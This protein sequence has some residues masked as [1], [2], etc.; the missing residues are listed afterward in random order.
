MNN[1]LRVLFFCMPLCTSGQSAI[2]TSTPD[3]SAK[4]EVY[5]TNQGFLAPRVTLT[6]TGDVTT[7]KNAAG[8]TVTPATGLMV[9]NT[10]T[11]GTGSTAVTPG[12][13]AYSGSSWVR[14]SASPSVE[15]DATNIGA[16]P[17]GG[18]ISLISPD[19]TYSYS[20]LGEIS[21]P[22]GKWE[23]T[24]EFTCVISQLGFLQSMQLLNG[25]Y[26]PEYTIMN[27]YWISDESYATPVDPSYPLNVSGLTSG[28]LTADKSFSGSNVSVLSVSRTQSLQQMKFYI[29]NSGTGN[30]TYF[31]H[32]HETYTGVSASVDDIAP[33][34]SQSNNNSNRFYAV[35]IQ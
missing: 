7:I 4:F 15:V 12:Y 30:K 21:L 2:G 18:G 3:A 16:F 11:A 24:G 6:G 19:Y 20:P 13:Y 29:T 22:P 10:A 34:Y 1:F 35:K 28:G 17:V 23:I 32:W 27:T 25:W 33:S 14:M 5:S 31:L 9:Y 26:N 8:T